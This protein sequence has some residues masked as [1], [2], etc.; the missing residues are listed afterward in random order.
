M[1]TDFFHG[2]GVELALYHLR[3]WS[4]MPELRKSRIS[5]QKA[6]YYLRSLFYRKLLFTFCS[7]ALQLSLLYRKKLKIKIHI[8]KPKES[9]DYRERSRPI[10]F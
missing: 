2:A 5:S 9:F 1:L 8:E 6:G 3:T 10:A 7:T 4:L